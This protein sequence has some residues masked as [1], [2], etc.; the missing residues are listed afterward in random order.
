MSLFITGHAIPRGRSR[1]KTTCLVNFLFVFK[2]DLSFL[3]IFFCIYQYVFFLS[4]FI[5]WFFFFF[6]FCLLGPHPWHMEVPRSGVESEL[7]LPAYTTATVTWDPS[8][9]YD[10]YHSSWQHQILSP[11]SEAR[12]W[13][14][15]LMDTSW[16]LNLLSHNRTPRALTLAW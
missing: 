1:D 7:Q 12:D 6:F 4:N 9:T 11:M 8:H 14:W 15:N 10:L 3:C 2:Q 16:G 5:E 13:T